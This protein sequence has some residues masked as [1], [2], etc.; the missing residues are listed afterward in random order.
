MDS[1]SRAVVNL[2]TLSGSSDRIV[3]SRQAGRQ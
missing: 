1:R 2:I 3:G